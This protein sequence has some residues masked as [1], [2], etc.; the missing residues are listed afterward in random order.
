[1]RP[2]STSAEGSAGRPAWALIITLPMT[3]PHTGLEAASPRPQGSA[4][5]THT[6]GVVEALPQDIEDLRPLI[7]RLAS[8]AYPHTATVGRW[9][10]VRVPRGWNNVIYRAG[11]GTLAVAVK[12]TTRDARDRAGREHRAPQLLAEAGLDVAP[13]P[14]GLIRDGLPHPVAI[15]TWLDGVVSDEPPAAEGEWEHLVRHYAAI[16]TVTPA[17]RRADLPAAGVTIP[18]T[19]SGPAL[20]R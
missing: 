18:G 19:S 13:K 15:S 10:A 4:G 16:H 7:D 6:A 17:D 8:C 14:L 2:T 12:F 9:R 20:V 1:S 11:A 5:P 3:V